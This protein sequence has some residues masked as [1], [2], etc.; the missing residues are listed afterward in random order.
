VN[1]CIKEVN[2]RLNMSGKNVRVGRMESVQ[3]VQPRGGASA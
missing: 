3:A 2:V 1:R